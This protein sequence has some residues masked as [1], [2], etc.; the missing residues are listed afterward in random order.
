MMVVVTR[1]EIIEV[2]KNPVLSQL[3]HQVKNLYNRANYLYKQQLRKKNSLSYYD[4]DK[5]IKFEECYKMLP[6]QTAQ[7]T[8]KYLIRNWKAYFQATYEW[9]KD[10]SKFLGFP[11]S[12]SY[13]PSN[14]ECVAIFCNQQAKIVNSW[15][16]L[17]RRISFTIK[18]RLH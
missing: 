16:I 14:G 7:Q 10:S 12:P 8:L 5:L 1:T 2:G 17:P 11:R 15:L 13:K 4:L 18:T 3:C 6:A 9:K